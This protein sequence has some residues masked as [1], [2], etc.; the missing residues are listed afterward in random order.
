MHG[1]YTYNS[2]DN[3]H[4][5]NSIITFNTGETVVIDIPPD[6]INKAIQR[7]ITKYKNTIWIKRMYI[8]YFIYKR[9]TVHRND[10][11][12]QLLNGVGLGSWRVRE[13]VLTLN[14]YKSISAICIHKTS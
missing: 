6:N 7:N 2:I 5:R 4:K 10:V 9:T 3:I 12:I 11:T 1:F 13:R 8:D 14:K